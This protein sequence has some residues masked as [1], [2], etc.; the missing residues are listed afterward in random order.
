[1]K[2]DYS[3]IIELRESGKRYDDAELNTMI[4]ERSHKIKKFFNTDVWRENGI[5]FYL[6]YDTNEPKKVN[7]PKD[8]KWGEVMSEIDT[9]I[10]IRDCM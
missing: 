2:L 6:C 7:L 5:W 8:C 1:M 10:Q 3:K 4:T 9:L